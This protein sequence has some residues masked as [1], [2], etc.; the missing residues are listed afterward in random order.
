MSQKLF[1]GKLSKIKNDKTYGIFHML[2]DLPPQHMENSLV[3][4]YCLKIISESFWDFFI[5]FPLKD[6]KY[7]ENF[8]DLAKNSE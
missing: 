5:F 2:V 6:Q 7:L 4:F 3:I 8:H 1:L